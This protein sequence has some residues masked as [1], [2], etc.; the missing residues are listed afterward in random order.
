LVRGG[1]GGQPAV[2]AQATHQVPTLCKKLFGMP[3]GP[4]SVSAHTTAMYECAT[5]RPK[6]IRVR[7]ENYTPPN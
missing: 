6:L 5:R 1:G 7:P 3:V 4:F 2:R